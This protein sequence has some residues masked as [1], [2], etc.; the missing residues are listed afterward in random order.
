[1]IYYFYFNSFLDYLIRKIKLASVT[2]VGHFDLFHISW[3]VK[4]R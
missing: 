1:M 4:I 2:H 3:G